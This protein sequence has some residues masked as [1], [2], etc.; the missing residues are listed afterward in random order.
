MEAFVPTGI[1]PGYCGADI[2]R[3]AEMVDGQKQY[4]VVMKNTCKQSKMIMTVYLSN[5]DWNS[6]QY[7]YQS[8]DSE[9]QLLNESQMTDCAP[10]RTAPNL[11]GCNFELGITK[12]F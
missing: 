9:G 10:H 3:Y 7:Q 8:F 2:K 12:D 11:V 4:S 6:I 5:E 1:T